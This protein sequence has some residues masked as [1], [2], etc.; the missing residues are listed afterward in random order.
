MKKLIASAIV[1]FVAIATVQVQAQTTTK[2]VKKELKSEKKAAHKAL[3]KLEGKEVSSRAKDQFMS[4][5]DGVS[6]VSWARGAQFDEA[7]FTK[8]G[9]KM[10]AYYDYDSKL[11]GTTS[12][13]KFADLP[14]SAQ[15]EIKKRY[16]DYTTGAVIMYD[17]NENN[18]TDMFFYGT[19]FEDADHYFVTV[20]K[21]GKE[22]ILK[23]ST[24]GEVS[25]FKQG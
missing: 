22:S 18:D 13:K 11:V 4:D 17:D 5:F 10:T 14:A 9:V 12:I 25:F 15:K 24:D 21:A 3:R 6:N 1:A 19:Q 20:S 2:E 16:K 23:V 7:T 8:D